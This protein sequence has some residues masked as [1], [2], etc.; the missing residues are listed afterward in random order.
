MLDDD[1]IFKTFAIDLNNGTLDERRLVATKQIQS[2]KR[3]ALAVF[4]L[5]AGGDAAQDNRQARPS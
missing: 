3:I 4:R 5:F 2:L 1:R